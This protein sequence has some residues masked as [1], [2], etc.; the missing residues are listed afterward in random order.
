MS[1]KRRRRRTGNAAVCLG[2]HEAPTVLSRRAEFCPG[3]AAPASSS[4]SM[5][6]FAAAVPPRMGR[7]RIVA[8]AELWVGSPGRPLP[9]PGAPSVVENDVV[10]GRRCARR[11]VGA[12]N[13]VRGSSM[14]PQPWGTRCWMRRRRRASTGPW[15]RAVV[16]TFL[17]GSGAPWAPVTSTLGEG[18]LA[19]AVFVGNKI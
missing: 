2:P 19:T 8:S 18:M 17:L 5:D 16:Y 6:V 7:R 1:A 12:K 10:F 14:A 11:R 15:G 4:L 3:S 13:G 9:S